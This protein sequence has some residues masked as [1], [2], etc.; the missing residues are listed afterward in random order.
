MVIR[1]RRKK[2]REREMKDNE[3]PKPTPCNLTACQYFTCQWK[4]DQFFENKDE[5]S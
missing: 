4:K 5:F 2:T 1:K 3:Q